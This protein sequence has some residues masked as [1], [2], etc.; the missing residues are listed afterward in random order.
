ME[1]NIQEKER[2]REEIR[3]LFLLAQS[4]PILGVEPREMEPGEA[5]KWISN[6]TAAVGDDGEP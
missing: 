2:A 5:V 6:I 4:H 3:D 1:P